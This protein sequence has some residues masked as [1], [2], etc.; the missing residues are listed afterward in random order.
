MRFVQ[1]L[2]MPT[3]SSLKTTD[4]GTPG[5]QNTSDPVALLRLKLPASSWNNDAAVVDF[6]L[7]LLYPGEGAANLGRD[8]EAA[9]T[10]LN[11]DDLGTASSSFS[12]LSGAAYDGRVRSM[13]AFLMSLPRFQE[14]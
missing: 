8:R 14:Q 10:Y 11:L 6:F 9:I 13:V 5:R 1:H 7:A 2:L 12:G 4:Y 3:T